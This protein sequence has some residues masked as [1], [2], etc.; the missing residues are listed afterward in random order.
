MLYHKDILQ[1]KA[2]KDFVY[3]VAEKKGHLAPFA[4]KSGVSG[5]V[6]GK[7]C[8]GCK[9]FY[10]KACYWPKHLEECTKKED[11]KK[12]LQSLLPDAVELKNTEESIAPESDQVA[13]LLLR[14]QKLEKTNKELTQELQDKE[15]DTEQEFKKLSKLG[16]AMT[17]FLPIE[18]RRMIGDY[19]NIHLDDEE[20]TYDYDYTVPLLTNEGS[21]KNFKPELWDRIRNISLESS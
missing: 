10:A 1:D 7:C 13:K 15:E 12:F 3:S 19:V 4:S 5:D 17:K 20:D 8:F 16:D 18:A 6:K 21:K 2:K 14:I 9:S 11:H